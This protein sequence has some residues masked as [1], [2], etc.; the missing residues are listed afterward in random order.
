MNRN[1]ATGL[2][3]ISGGLLW[4][5]AGLVHHGSYEA[6]WL[7]ADI[8]LLLGLIGLWTL[9]L[10]GSA[11]AGRIGLAIAVTGRGVLIAA[12]VVSIVQGSDE[13]ALLPLGALS[14]A[15]GLTIYGVSVLRQ[16]AVGGA[17]RFMPLIVGVYPFLTMFP[18]VIARSGDPSD[19]AISI[20]GAP[21]AALGLA[22]LVSRSESG[23][24]TGFA[25]VAGTR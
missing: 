10:H 9:R 4:L 3:W 8:L 23:A 22:T 7:P 12:E 21:M 6:I 14:S 20:W 18:I 5:I 24:H 11:R 17:L 13:N 19:V 16:P 15:I 2:A 25:G 1:A